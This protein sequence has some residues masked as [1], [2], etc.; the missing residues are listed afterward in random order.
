VTAERKAQ[1]V[2]DLSVNDALY[3]QPGDFI[4]LRDLSLSYDLPPNMFQRM[5]VE[6]A[7][8]QMAGH[9]LGIL[10]KKG[11]KGPDPEVN[12][13]GINGPGLTQWNLV[14][15]D[16]WTMPMTRRVTFSLDLSF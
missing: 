3:T 15:T 10:W 13:S 12:M 6:R 7:A 14:R 4:K 16:L 11:Y 1:L 5:G 2:A 9:N 8:V